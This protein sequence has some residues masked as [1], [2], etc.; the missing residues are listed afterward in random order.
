MNNAKIY[1]ANNYSIS[2]FTIQPPII[3]TLKKIK[4]Y[5]IIIIIITTINYKCNN[6][7]LK[8]P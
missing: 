3:W 2:L 5:L 4:I 8:M 6:K 1:I 7:I